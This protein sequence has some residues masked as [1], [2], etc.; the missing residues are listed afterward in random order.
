MSDER[1]LWKGGRHQLSDCLAG[2]VLLVIIK[3]I[4]FPFE[5][6]KPVSRWWGFVMSLLN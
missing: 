5:F 4:L 1:S 2:S 6:L 3:K